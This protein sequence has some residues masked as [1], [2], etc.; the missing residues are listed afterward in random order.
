MAMAMLAHVASH[1]AGFEAWDIHVAD[2]R[3][4]MVRLVFWGVV[5]PKV[6]K[7]D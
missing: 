7:L 4:A 5:G 2:L 1:Q 6:P 3:Q